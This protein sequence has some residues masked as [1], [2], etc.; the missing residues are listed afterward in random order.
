[1]HL[2]DLGPK[3]RATRG[4]LNTHTHTHTHVYMIEVHIIVGLEEVVIMS[5]FV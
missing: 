5:N 4:F 2:N 3:N 1:M